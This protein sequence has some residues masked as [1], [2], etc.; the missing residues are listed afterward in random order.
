MVRSGIAVVGPVLV[1]LLS[2]SALA[3][4]RAFTDAVTESGIA[5][6]R[7]CAGPATDSQISCVASALESTARQLN[8]RRDYFTAASAFLEASQRVRSAAA[9]PGPIKEKVRIT[10]TALEG[11]K[12]TLMS[13]A[14]PEKVEFSRLTR[15][16]ETA[17]GVLKV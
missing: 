11:V 2:T 1:A 9:T 5:E 8:S 13:S 7:A 10:R 3:F 6:V 14:G 12:K 16:P 4:D 15:V 17:K